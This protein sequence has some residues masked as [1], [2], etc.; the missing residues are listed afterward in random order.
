[1]TRINDRG[2]L[3][4]VRDPRRDSHDP[5][6]LH[7]SSSLHDSDRNEDDSNTPLRMADGPN[8]L[9]PTGSGAHSGPSTPRPKRSPGPES[10]RAARNATAVARF[11]YTRKPVPKQGW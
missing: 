5:S 2:D 6:G 8:A 4:R 11:R 7:A 3:R 9:P 10:A 1:M